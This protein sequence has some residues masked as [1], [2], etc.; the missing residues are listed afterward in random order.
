VLIAPLLIQIRRASVQ[1]KTGRARSILADRQ[2]RASCNGHG[3]A[4]KLGTQARSL[5]K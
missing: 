5:W 1:K 2:D 4:G 3:I